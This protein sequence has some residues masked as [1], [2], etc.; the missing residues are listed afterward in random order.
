MSKLKNIKTPNEILSE[1]AFK[2]ALED[3]KAKLIKNWI[4]SGVLNGL[5]LSDRADMSTLLGSK[6][7]Q[8]IPR[9]TNE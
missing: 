1:L 6:S 5:K 8:I 4:E 7:K 9:T 3:R 2:S